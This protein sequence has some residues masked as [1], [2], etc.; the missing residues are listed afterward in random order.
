MW[1]VFSCS[2]LRAV[3][4]NPAR[5][6]TGQFVMDGLAP[7]VCSLLTWNLGLLLKVNKTGVRKMMKNVFA[8]QQNLTT[9]I[10]RREASFDRL[11]SYYEL[12]LLGDE[13]EV[14]AHIDQRRHE[15]KQLFTADQYR[16]VLEL[17]KPGKKVSAVVLQSLLQ[18]LSE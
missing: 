14:F 1:R 17:Q 3:E 12:L 15:G 9:A 11:R 5:E 13:Q 16:V 2:L 8:V 18:K 7:L 10:A 4:Q 6:R